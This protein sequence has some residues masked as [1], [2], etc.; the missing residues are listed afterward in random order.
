MV[1][2]N[3]PR[4]ADREYVTTSVRFKPEVLRKLKILA[5][6]RGQ[7]LQEM[8]EQGLYELLARQGVNIG[9]LRTGD[10]NQERA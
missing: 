7:S 8:I 1:K 4:G 10:D 2:D 3:R 9:G 6:E 5:I